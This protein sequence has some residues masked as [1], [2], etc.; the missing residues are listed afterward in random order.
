MTVLDLGCV[1]DFFSIKMAKMVGS[2][3]KV[4][5]AGLQ[6]GMPEIVNSG[7]I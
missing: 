2:Y 4:V 1:P 6:Q 5:V 3:G 7:Q